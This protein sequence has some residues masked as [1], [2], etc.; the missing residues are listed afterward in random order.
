MNQWLVVRMEVD[1]SS[2]LEDL[3]EA[4]V[5]FLRHIKGFGDGRELSRPGLSLVGHISVTVG[6]YF[7]IPGI[8]SGLPLTNFIAQPEMAPNEMFP[9]FLAVAISG[10]RAHHHPVG[11]GENI[12]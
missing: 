7:S 3:E 2:L 9:S 8:E 11:C 10:E 6:L 12:G 4:V 1:C 5:V